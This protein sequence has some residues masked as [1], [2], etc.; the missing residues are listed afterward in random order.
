MT[1]EGKHQGEMLRDFIRV[2]NISITDLA[3]KL[4]IS[5]QALYLWFGKRQLPPDA[6]DSLNELINFNPYENPDFTD[7]KKNSHHYD[8]DA[9]T[10]V[11]A[12]VYY[13]PLFCIGGFLAGY[14]NRVFMDS[15]EKFYLPGIEGEH[16]AFE[17]DG[18][19]MWDMASPG[20][21]AIARQIERLEW[22]MKGKPYVLQT[23][24]GI[25][26]KIFDKIKDERAYFTSY[27]KEMDG[28]DFPLKS[29]KRVYF[30]TRI[31][32]KI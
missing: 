14:R 9:T 19:S 25:Y 5:R 22:M 1:S 17:V 15:L 21:Y 4:D 12:N 8:Q 2:K 16:F 11:K 13:V 29:I 18:M 31:L 7:V 32:K 24:D 26:I 20:D 23:I 10:R 30:V 3:E 6:I 27:N 28:I